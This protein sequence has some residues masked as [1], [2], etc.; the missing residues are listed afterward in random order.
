MESPRPVALQFEEFLGYDL[1]IRDWIS[2]DDAQS[3]ADADETK[4]IFAW[5]CEKRLKEVAEIEFWV[6]QI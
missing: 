1:F 3:K 5:L 6:R 2:E 4:R